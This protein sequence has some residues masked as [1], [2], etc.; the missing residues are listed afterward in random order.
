MCFSARHNA[1]YRCLQGTSDLGSCQ[2]ET[3]PSLPFAPRSGEKVAEGRMRGDPAPSVPTRASLRPPYFRNGSRLRPTW[4]SPASQWFAPA[5][6]AGQP[7]V[8]MV[9]ASVPRGTASRPNGSRL[10]PT[11]GGST[12]QWFAPPSR[13]GQ[14]YEP[15]V[16]AHVPRGAAPRTNGS[17]PRRTCD[18]PTNQ[19][20]APPPHVRQPHEPT[21][22]APAPREAARRTKEGGCS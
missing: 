13:A 2:G 22:G 7:R 16:R 21:V 15:M 11:W 4:D 12:S 19:R 8:S 3:L 5:S 17:H 10:R 1:A 14:P 6:R 20:F 9:R 18:S